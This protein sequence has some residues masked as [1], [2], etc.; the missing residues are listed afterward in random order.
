MPL[1]KKF[2]ASGDISVDTLNHLFS[3]AD[4][5]ER[6]MR[7]RGRTDLLSDKVIAL[8]FFEPSSRT[9]MSFQSAGQRLQ[10]G[11]L[12]L[13]GE[14]T[15]LKKGESI[16]DTMKV[17]A[18]YCD[19]IVARLPKAGSAEVAAAASMVPFINAGDGSNE[20]PTQALI[21][22]YSIRRALG[23]INDIHVAVGLDP[24]QS[25]AIHSLVRL[26]S[27]F[28]G[29]RF[30]FLSPEILRAPKELLNELVSRGIPFSETEDIDRIYDADVIYFN[31]LQEERFADSNT[32]EFYRHRYVLKKSM[33]TDKV[34]LIL[35]PLPRIDEIALDVDDHPAA[36][37]F[38]QAHNGVPVRMAVLSDLLD[39][40]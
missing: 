37:Y 22:A 38:R 39:R 36:A 25:R 17:V 10:A 32:F 16:E 11:V 6:L 15:S 30:T 9:M 21:D 27:K 4:D 35:D 18:G 20:H 23:R 12:L 19:L 1:P 13:Q 28:S 29:V 34:K 26:L 2:I 8:L 31:R 40:A 5:M 14:S 3:V 33:I 24:L 7:L